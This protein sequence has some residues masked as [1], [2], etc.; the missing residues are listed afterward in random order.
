MKKY[1]GYCGCKTADY[2]MGGHANY[3]HGLNTHPVMEKL[4]EVYS[5]LKNFDQEHKHLTRPEKV[6]FHN[7]H[8]DLEDALIDPGM[9]L[10]QALKDLRKEYEK[11]HHHGGMDDETESFYGDIRDFAKKVIALYKTLEHRTGLVHSFI[12]DRALI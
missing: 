7:R 6:D 2:E 1:C 9:E 5:D 8:S 4:H 11:E 3:E 10:K 12:D